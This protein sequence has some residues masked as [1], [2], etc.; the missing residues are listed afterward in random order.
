MI[1]IKPSDIM[2]RE[3]WL[4]AFVPAGPLADLRIITLGI[5]NHGRFFKQGSS[6]V[7]FS[8]KDVRCWAYVPTPPEDLLR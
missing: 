1:W 7:S 5:V 8:L 6:D 4:I 2:P 3:N